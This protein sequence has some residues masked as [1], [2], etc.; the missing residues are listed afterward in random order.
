[1]GEITLRQVGRAIDL[2]LEVAFRE[3]KTPENLPRIPDGESDSITSCV[4][5]LFRDESSQLEGGARCFSLR[6]G[7][8]R[9]PFMK[10]LIQECLFRD[11]FFFAVD[12]HDQMFH[13]QDDPKLATLM[14][15]N[16]EV[17]ASIEAAWEGAGLPAASGLRGLLECSPIPREPRRDVRI[18]LVDDTVA[19]QETIAQMLDFMG[20][21]VDLASDGLEALELADPERHALILMDVEMPRMDGV[22]ACMELRR[23]PR[24]RQIPILLASAGA[25]E[26]A[27]EA[28]P[29]GYLVKPFRADA[30]RQY[31]DSLLGEPAGGDS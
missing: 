5:E 21:D 31:L 24:R 6:L 12:T 2:Y 9:Y 18:L 8:A 16:R 28:S 22:E 19:V 1:M 25:I 30:L 26:M 4:G 29:D 17:K 27:R 7:N 23:D 13:A 11:E 15:Y 10:F 20:Y 3:A 14:A